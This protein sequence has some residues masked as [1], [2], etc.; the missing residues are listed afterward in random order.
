MG[1]ENLG[2]RRTREARPGSRRPRGPSTPP[3]YILRESGSGA[4]PAST[5][6]IHPKPFLESA[7]YQTQLLKIRI[8]PGK[9]EQVVDFVRSLGDRRDDAMAAL[10][11]EGMMIESLFLE[12]REDGDYLYYYV[13]ARNLAEANDINMRSNDPLTLE[14]RRFV[15]D[16]WGDMASPEPLLDLDLIPETGESKAGKKK[17]NIPANADQLPV[18]GG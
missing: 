17:G 18:A 12:R 14:I 15:A 1:K 5:G 7:M 3:F 6:S 16:T 11:R 4:G 8:R 10:R 2:A 13:K 9:T